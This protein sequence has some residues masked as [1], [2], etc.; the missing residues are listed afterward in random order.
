MWNVLSFSRQNTADV[1]APASI[2][3]NTSFTLL[4]VCINKQT[5][6]LQ[7]SANPSAPPLS[8]WWCDM[9]NSPESQRVS[10]LPKLIIIIICRYSQTLLASFASFCFGKSLIAHSNCYCEIERSLNF[11]LLPS[12]DDVDDFISWRLGFFCSPSFHPCSPH[13]A[14]FVPNWHGN[15][16]KKSFNLSSS[17]AAH[18]SFL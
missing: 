16:Q 6:H 1:E 5:Y 15:K 7:T 9:W 11:H 12:R 3:S 4:F 2:G 14:L 10:K 8:W 13:T 17:S 18:S